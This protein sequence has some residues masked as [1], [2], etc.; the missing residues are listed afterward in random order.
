[1]KFILSILTFLAL[2]A[3][4]H[5]QS[6]EV[7]TN[8]TV[9]LEITKPAAW[10]HV[11]AEAT[12]ENFRN[13]EMK[14]KEFQEAVVKYATAPVFAFAKYPEPYPDINPSFKINLRSAGQLA[15]R[16]GS[17]ILALILPTLQNAFADFV[18]QEG[19]TETMVSGLPAS[20]ARFNYTL[21]AGGAEYPTTSEIWIVPRGNFF[22]LIGAGTRQDEATGSRAEIRSIL[23]SVK[24]DRQR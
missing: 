23:D 7:V 22:F 8:R 1:M 17:E 20:Y 12:V 14:D 21:S 4:A 3:V 11:T 9:G 2:S 10:Q 24:I 13:V 16:S 19:P 5:A 6:D 15:G 18:M